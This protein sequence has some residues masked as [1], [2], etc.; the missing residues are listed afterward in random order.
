MKMLF[1]KLL[2]SPGPPI[3][4]LVPLL[5]CRG[6]VNLVP[7]PNKFSFAD[8]AFHKVGSFEIIFRAIMH[9]EDAPRLHAMPSERMMVRG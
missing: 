4:S 9:T 6:T 5:A 2:H 3:P 7:S 1:N 8:R